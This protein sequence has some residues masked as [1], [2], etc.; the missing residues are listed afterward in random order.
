MTPTLSPP[1]ILTFAVIACT[2]TLEV[3]ARRLHRKPDTIPVLALI[4]IVLAMVIWLPSWARTVVVGAGIVFLGLDLGAGFTVFCLAVVAGAGLWLPGGITVV[5]LGILVIVGLEQVRGARRHLIR[6]ARAAALTADEPTGDEVELTGNVHAVVPTVDPVHG[7]PCAMWK[8]I[9]H[10][11][12]ES[13]VMVELR[14]AEGSA[15]VDP[16]TVRLDWSQPTSSI[17]GERAREVAEKLRLDLTST[18]SLF[19]QILPEGTECYVVGV[20][21][22]ELAPAPTVGTYRDAPMLPTFRS[23]PEHPAWFADRS[24]AQLHSDY[25]WALASW[26]IW[27]AMCAAIAGAQLLGLA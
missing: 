22:W 15:I 25:G 24:E 3:I 10:G 8:V 20:P 13:Q 26:G 6:L 9:G 5:L 18:G 17:D 7:E 27:G 12:R 16:E 21:G 1:M 23:T 11:T 19:L 4:A 2:V 14:G